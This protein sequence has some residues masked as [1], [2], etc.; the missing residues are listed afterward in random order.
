MDNST[1]A[2]Y[3]V[4]TIKEEGW[5]QKEIRPLKLSFVNIWIQV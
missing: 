1:Y 2:W 4:V 3:I 5:C